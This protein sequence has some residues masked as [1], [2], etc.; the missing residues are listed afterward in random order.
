MAVLQSDGVD[1]TSDLIL[2]RNGT[3]GLRLT[4]STVQLSSINDG[5]LAGTRNKIIN[6]AMEISQRG[7][8]FA[9]PAETYTL[10]RYLW[11]QTGTMV[12]TISQSTDVPNNT[13]QNSLKIDVT[14]ADTSIAAAD[15]AQIQQRI[16]GYNIRDLIGQTFTLSFWV[17][18]PKTGVHC[19]SFAGSVSDFRSYVLEYTVSSANT[20]E[21]KTLTVSGGLITAG[22]WN[23]T[24]G[25]GLIVS[26]T[27]AAGSNRQTTAGSW[28]TG[29]F[30]A[31]SNQVNVMDN[32]AND[33]YL[34][35]VQLEVGS[36][37]TPFERR[38]FG[39]ELALCQRYF[40]KTY[41]QSTA[42]G[43]AAASAL[44]AVAESGTGQAYSTIGTWDFPVTM[45]ASPS[46]TGYDTNTGTSGRFSGDSSNY[47]QL[48]IFFVGER[49]AT[50]VV[51]NLVIPVNTF[52]KVHAIAN[53]EL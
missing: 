37:A 21:Y 11:G 50:F 5:P 49:S 31:T 39:Q 2:R 9:A 14:T 19:V 51:N 25:I 52:L 13:F 6:G 24:N 28:N 10:D 36:V 29:N 40:A 46:I 44:G 48:T 22:T 35:G 53:A 17:K 18:S 20:W 12:V 3:E 41:N 4:S 38:S 30:F 32:T 26:F 16:E 33:F 43:T 27:L 42:P 23:W 47:T 15:L 7:T 34:T 45:R 8:S 1:H